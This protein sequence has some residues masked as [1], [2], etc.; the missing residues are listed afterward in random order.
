MVPTR[1]HDSPAKRIQPVVR[2]AVRRSTIAKRL[3]ARTVEATTIY[4]EV[5]VCLEAVHYY[6][7][8]GAKRER[9]PLNFKLRLSLEEELKINRF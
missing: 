5:E 4:T 1:Y 8:Y 6:C 2:R 3:S 7:F 9:A